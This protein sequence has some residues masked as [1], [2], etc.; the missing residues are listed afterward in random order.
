MIGRKKS[1]GDLFAVKIVNKGFIQKVG[2]FTPTDH[3]VGGEN[4]IRHV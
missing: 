2:D 3:L 1:G 4:T